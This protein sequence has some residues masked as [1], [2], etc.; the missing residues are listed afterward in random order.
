M[1]WEATTLGLVGLAVG[2]PAGVVLGA[3]TWRVVADGLGVAAGSTIP[4]VALAL[5]A[6]ATLVLV[7][8]IAFLP[9]RAAA[10]CRPAVALRSE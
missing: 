7:N 1:A 4:F 6:V 10:N 8:V 2:I 3:L 9:A 5:T